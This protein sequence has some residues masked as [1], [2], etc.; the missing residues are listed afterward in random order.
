M[1]GETAAAR[2]SWIRTGAPTQKIGSGLP[3]PGRPKGALGQA[4]LVKLASIH[5]YFRKHI[6]EAIATHVEI[7]NNRDYT[8]TVRLDAASK[9]LDRIYGRPTQQVNLGGEDGGPLQHAVNISFT[10]PSK[11]ELRTLE[12]NAEQE[13]T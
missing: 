10:I 8:P 4:S 6:E 7:M 11:E 2:Q 3:G 5:E 12:L 13:K 1:N 9:I